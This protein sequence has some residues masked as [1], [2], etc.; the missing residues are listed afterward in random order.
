MSKICTKCVF[1]HIFFTEIWPISIGANLRL[2][3][4]TWNPTCHFFSSTSK[5]CIK[6]C[7]GNIALEC[8]F[9]AFY[10]ML[11]DYLIQ[12]LGSE[13]H[14]SKLLL[15]KELSSFKLI[16]GTDCVCT[17]EDKWYK[18]GRSYLGEPAENRA[19]FPGGSG[20][21][22]T[23]G[24]AVTIMLSFHPHATVTGYGHSFCP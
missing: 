19:T 10:P 13:Y 8:R 17:A 6:I 23:C 1:R 20:K 24:G 3:C 11:S 7:S 21:P 18:R 2:R 15:C 14:W 22:M 5:F 9:S 12:S 4:L 16:P